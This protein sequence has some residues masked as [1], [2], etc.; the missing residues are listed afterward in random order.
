MRAESRQ[1]AKK[2]SNTGSANTAFAA[3]TAFGGNI[4]PPVG[5]RFSARSAEAAFLESPAVM[6]VLNFSSA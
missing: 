6:L 1:K 2:A 5:W 4:P 3:L